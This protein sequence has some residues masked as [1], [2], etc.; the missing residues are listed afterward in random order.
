MTQTSGMYNEI[1]FL[2][3]DSSHQERTGNAGH[4]IKL[5][6]SDWEA[7]VKK[8]ATTFGG[9]RRV[10]AFESAHRS[11]RSKNAAVEAYEI[12]PLGELSSLQEDESRYFAMAVTQK[13]NGHLKL[14]TVAWIKEPLESWLAT[15][16]DE[17][18]N[19]LGT[20]IYNY[21]LPSISDGAGSCTD[22]T[23]S[24]TSGPPDGREGHTAVWTG[25]EMI[26]WGG[27]IYPI[28]VYG[29]GGRYNPSTDTW[30]GTS[31]TGAPTPRALHAAVWTGSEMIVWGGLDQNG[32]DLNTGARYDPDYG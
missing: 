20:A 29:T 19:V 18:P 26:I 22:D 25:S 4:T 31:M 30:T 2:K 3:S 7:T 24:A 17:I 15:M 6:S 1:E 28:A 27:E 13:S 32:F 9:Q 12:V 23:W 11:A 5:N 14:A 8:L 10:S 16:Q 21:R